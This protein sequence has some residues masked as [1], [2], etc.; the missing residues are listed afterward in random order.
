MWC[1]RVQAFFLSCMVIFASVAFAQPAPEARHTIRLRSRTVTVAQGVDPAVD[2]RGRRAEAAGAPAVHLIL[3]AHDVLPPQAWERLAANGIE[4]V[5]YLGGGNYVVRMAWPPRSR[6]TLAH[7]LR[8]AGGLALTPILPQDKV[9]PRVTAGRFDDRVFDAKSGLLA[10]TV[11]FFPGTRKE[12]AVA[13]LRSFH[14]GIEPPEELGPGLW[15][16]RIVPSD[17]AKLAESE[18]V[19]DIDVLVPRLP[20]MS[21]A[22][23]RMSID[24]LHQLDLTSTGSLYAQGLSGKG[25]RISTL[26]GLHDHDDFWNHDATG[27]RTTHRVAPGCAQ[28]LTDAHGAMTAGIALGNGFGSAIRGGSAYQWRGVAPEAILTCSGSEDVVSRSFVQTY[29]FYTGWS[30]SID[31]AVR[32]DSGGDRKPQVWAVANQGITSQYGIEKGYYSVYAPAKNPVVVANISA[33][34][35]DWRYSS[36]GPTFDGRIKPDVS[37]PGTKEGWP[38]DTGQILVDLD[39]VKLN[40][41]GGGSLVW[42]F[43][44]TAWQGGWGVPGW[45]T[46]QD[47]GPVSQSIQG[48]TEALRVPLLP[49]PHGGWRHAPMVGTLTQPGGAPL[50]I[51]ASVTDSLEVRYRADAN[52]LWRP[53]R[54]TF[55]WMTNPNTYDGFATP[56][57][58]VAD[59]QWHTATVRIGLDPNWK[60]TSTEKIDYLSFL[61]GAHGML[62]PNGLTQ[63]SGAGGSSASAPGVTG[64]IALLAEQAVNEFGVQVTNRT[65]PSPYWRDANGNPAPGFGMPLPSTFKALLIHGARDL[66]YQPHSDEPDN[67]DTQAKT[68]Y[69]DGPDLATGYGVVD[70][71][72]SAR[73]VDA[74]TNAQ[75][76]VVERQI[77]NGIQHTYTVTVPV[78]PRAPLKVTLVWDDP[79][80][81]PL[82]DDVAPHL[83]NNL[84]LSL[85]AP[86]GMVFHP[87]VIDPPYTPS[88]S[89]DYPGAIEPEPI[90]AANVKPARTGPNSLD[91]VEQVYV[92][93]PMPGAWTVRVNGAQLWLGPQKYSLV[94]RTP[95]QPATHLNGGKVVFSSDRVTPTQI[96]VKQVGSTAAPVQVSSDFLPS[97]HPRWSPNGKYIAYITTEVIGG[98][99]GSQV[100]ALKIISESGAYQTMVHANKVGAMSMGYPQWADDGKRIVVTYWSSWP[101]RGLAVLTFASAN[102]FSALPVVTTLVAPGGAIN[103]GEAVFS[104]DGDF[105]YFMGDSGSGPS[106]LYRIPAAGGTPVP[107]YGNGIHV[108]RAFAPSVSPDGTR[109]IFNSEMWNEDPVQYKDEEV[110]ELGFFTG[111]VRQVTSEPGHQYAWFARNGAG[112]TV[113]QSSATPAGKTELFLEENGVR[114]PLD[115]ADP[116]NQ[117]AE[118][119]PDW[120]KP[121]CG[122]GTAIWA[123]GE[124]VGC[125]F[126]TWGSEQQSLC[127]AWTPLV[128]TGAGNC[129]VCI[130][131]AYVTAVTSGPWTGLTEGTSSTSTTPADFTCRGCLTPPAQMAGWWPLDET[132]GTTAA[133]ISTTGA[134]GTHTGGPAA[135]AGKVA[136][137]LKFNGTT[138][139]VQV[140]HNTAQ[141]VGTGDF[142]VDAWVKIDSPAD[143]GGIRVILEKRQS[144]PWRGYSFFL[145][146][147]QVALQLADGLGSQYSNYLSG[148][149]VPADG[150]WHLVAVT[151]KRTSAAGGQFYL[152]GLPAGPP[153]NP[154]G[155]A[156]TLANTMPLRIGSITTGVGSLFKGS[157]D[158]VE[159]YQRALTAWENQ[160]LYVAG[161][162]GKCK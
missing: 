140:P 31:S 38:E 158:E 7:N 35:N 109:L 69:H 22:R 97:R 85:T 24:P 30:A 6:A 136:G 138:A 113:M 100:D 9:S 44:G 102:S 48:S 161:P 63:Y 150:Q 145:Y 88:N 20:L 111:V 142:S 84:N 146:N 36:I 13:L 41:A 124:V 130:D 89:S 90:V 93:N 122:G 155:R 135:V 137:G 42:N 53:G 128:A 83:V 55:A 58:L 95:P 15:T 112:E 25:V 19:H 12:S 160:M 147:G 121:P 148:M 151:V 143:L 10:V 157:I 46:G 54:L 65:S 119:G 159:L 49:P 114:V 43:S 32:G 79:A 59:G 62:V 107:V 86:N 96:F 116:T 18:L 162:C 144:S 77:S 125:K 92:A 91:N 75:P 3:G 2:E 80:G 129:N 50:S 14:R 56:I 105:V 60:T 17:A 28:S 23:A 4:R 73:I 78:S 82:F 72:A 141:N 120:W 117:W 152:D 87:Y 52:R 37:S 11:L 51:T 153:F 154:T 94:L 71:A 26:E 108:R 123:N 34:T 132:S 133:D 74:H 103:P 1:S 5:S 8:A 99:S 131:A 101:Q 76:S 45:W 81:D 47:I 126:T 40:L 149:T 61:F 104:R 110:L 156:G 66:A 39:F 29:G 106:Q 33:S 98:G 134:A 139:Y 115:V 68:I 27:A 21:D 57:D 64:T 67:P 127:G 16:I 70:A 118:G